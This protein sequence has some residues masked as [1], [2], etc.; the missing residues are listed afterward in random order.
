MRI[1]GLPDVTV[2]NSIKLGREAD[3]TGCWERLLAAPLTP[4]N[5]TVSPEARLVKVNRAE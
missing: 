3:V 1:R 2:T 5:G 4:S